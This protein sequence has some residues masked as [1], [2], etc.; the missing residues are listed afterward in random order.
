MSLGFRDNIRKPAD[1]PDKK[2]QLLPTRGQSPAQSKKMGSSPKSDQVSYSILSSDS[3]PSPEKEPAHRRGRRGCPLP[4][5]ALGAS[6]VAQWLRIHLPMQ[7]YRFKPWSGKIPHAAEQLSPCT[8]TTEPAFWSPQATTT[9]A[10]APRAR[11]L[12]QE[13]PL[14]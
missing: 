3:R 14:Q 13:K 4:K 12:Q 5:S 10:R 6:L 8:T 11:A 1:Q 7:G 9:E 2:R